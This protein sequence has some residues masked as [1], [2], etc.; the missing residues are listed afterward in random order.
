[1]HF[2]YLGAFLTIAAFAQPAAPTLS[3]PVLTSPSAQV[4]R[5]STRAFG[6]ELARHDY[7]A[8][9]SSIEHLQQT[10]SM[11]TRWPHAKLTMAM[12]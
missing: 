8:Y 10:F 1:M 6:P 11:S 3:P 9:M 4:L 7:E 2:A 12:R 5:L